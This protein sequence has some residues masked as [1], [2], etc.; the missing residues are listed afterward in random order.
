MPIISDHRK[1]LVEALPT[2]MNQ[3]EGGAC[4]C[5]GED[6]KAPNEFETAALAGM[7]AIETITYAPY[8]HSQKQAVLRALRAEIDA[9]M[10]LVERF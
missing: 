1:K 10:K 7:A 2:F 6:V 4:G 3:C 8:H 9:K 5:T